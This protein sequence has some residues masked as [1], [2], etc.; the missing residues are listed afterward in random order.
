MLSKTLA[1]A[2]GS[3]HLEHEKNIFNFPLKSSNIQATELIERISRLCKNLMGS[4]ATLLPDPSVGTGSSMILVDVKQSEHIDEIEFENLASMMA[5][6][7][8]VFSLNISEV[9]SVVGVQRPTIYAWINSDSIPHDSNYKRLQELFFIAETVQTKFGTKL[10]KLQKGRNFGGLSVI[11]LLGREK[12]NQEEVIKHIS[13]LIGA[14][15][16]QE[17]RVRSFREMAKAA[18]KSISANQN[19][20]KTIDHLTGKRVVED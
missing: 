3:A 8:S 10:S 2:S 16:Q 20:Q 11:D 1:L 5:K 17:S 14:S 13:T 12:I 6:I 15:G 4:G 18:N 7:Q 19:S 9:A